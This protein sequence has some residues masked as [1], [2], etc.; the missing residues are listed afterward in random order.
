MRCKIN[1]KVTQ[2]LYIVI[3]EMIYYKD[4]DNYKI[5][6]ET[7]CFIGLGRGKLVHDQFALTD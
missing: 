5:F 7:R 2:P 6:G 3:K 1:F 4:N